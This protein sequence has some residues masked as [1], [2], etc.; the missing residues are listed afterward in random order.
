MLTAFNFMLDFAMRRHAVAFCS[1]GS[2]QLVIAHVHFH[3]STTRLPSR[4]LARQA[5]LFLSLFLLS[6]FVPPIRPVFYL[7]ELQ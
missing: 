4:D 1:S 5:L 6:F 3:S 2:A 7:I